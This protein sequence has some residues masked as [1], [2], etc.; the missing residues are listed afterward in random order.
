MIG[1]HTTTISSVDHA[2]I[3]IHSCGSGKAVIVEG[4]ALRG[5]KDYMPFATALA[6]KFEVHV[7]DRRGR[8][9]SSPL[10]DG[11]SLETEIADLLAVQEEVGASRVRA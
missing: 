3:G 2:T 8:G 5:A 6:G 4:G 11:Y 1:W 7:I 10:G 9:L